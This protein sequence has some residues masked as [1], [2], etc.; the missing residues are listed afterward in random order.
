MF[1]YKRMPMGDHVSMD[2]YNYRFNKV[3]QGVEN[4]KRCVDDSLLYSNS[5]KGAF[6]QAAS[7]L[8]LMGTNGIIQCPEKFQFGS[9]TLD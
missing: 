5:W 2:A 7:Y 1:R 6:H 8:H 3:T 9:K 4:K